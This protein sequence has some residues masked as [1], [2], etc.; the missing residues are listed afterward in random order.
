MPE[1]V[2]REIKAGEDAVAYGAIAALRPLVGSLSQFEEI[3]SKQRE[4]GYR[5]AVIFE[6]GVSE[7]VAVAGFSVGRRLAW[8]SYLCVED[9]SAHPDHQCE[10][11]VDQ[12][13]RWVVEEAK[14]LAVDS[15]HLDSEV[16]RFAAHRLY[17]RSGFRISAHHFQLNLEP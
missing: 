7:S 3:V 8:G 5:M 9:A 13:L 15:I 12:L 1:P 16:Q 4:G 14:R 10:G 17:L 11:H 6:A 2:V